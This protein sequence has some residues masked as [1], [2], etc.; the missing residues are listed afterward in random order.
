MIQFPKSGV[1]ALANA[2][3]ALRMNQATAAAQ[4]VQRSMGAVPAEYD[5]LQRYLLGVAAWRLGKLDVAAQAL[6]EV[7]KA[8]PRNNDAKR[9]LKQIQS[10]V[11]S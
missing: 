2:L 6:Q 9:L 4:F 7:I 1:L 8:N 5:T 10:S 3:V 11:R